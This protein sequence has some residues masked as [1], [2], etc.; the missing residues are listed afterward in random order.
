MGGTVSSPAGLES[1]AFSTFFSRIKCIV[2]VTLQVVTPKLHTVPMRTIG[3]DAAEILLGD[4]AEILFGDAPPGSAL[5]CVSEVI[6]NTDTEW[7]IKYKCYLLWLVI[8]NCILLATV[9]IIVV[10]YRY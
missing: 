4:A 9:F 2:L 7:A 8:H 5:T 1:S 3:M 6:G 10:G